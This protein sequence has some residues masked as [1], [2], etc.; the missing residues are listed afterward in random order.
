MWYFPRE[1]SMEDG[2]DKAAQR[3]TV[4]P[5]DVHAYG[6][7]NHQHRPVL[8]VVGV[9]SCLFL[10]ALG[11]GRLGMKGI[12]TLSA[13]ELHQDQKG[14]PSGHPSPVEWP[15]ETRLPLGPQAPHLGC[16]FPS[17]LYHP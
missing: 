11:E 3:S 15:K 6:L 9:L 4:H 1:A 13:P 5:Q 7:W 14:S 8:P 16:D 12:T 17:F 2:W 10:H